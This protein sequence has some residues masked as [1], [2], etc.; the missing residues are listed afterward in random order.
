MAH[1][2][3]YVHLRADSKIP[4]YVGKGKNHRA[5]SYSDRSEYWKRV[6]ERHGVIVELLHDNLTEAVAFQ[7]EVEEI[8]WFRKYYHLVNYCDGG[9]GATKDEQ[10]GEK[11]RKIIEFFDKNGRFPSRFIPGEEN[12]THWMH[13]YCSLARNCFDS[14]FSQWC[15]ERGY[16]N[17]H[18]KEEKKQK[19]DDIREF[20][21]ANG[22]FPSSHRPTEKPLWRNLLSYCSPSHGCYDPEFR[23]WCVSNGYARRKQKGIHKES[24]IAKQEEIKQFFETHNRFP[25]DR[26]PDERTLH[27]RL[28]SYC[29]PTQSSFDPEFNQWCRDRG[30]GSRKRQ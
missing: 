9:E 13:A 12:M 27:V 5:W 7:E 22:R 8:A 3:V 6:A 10:T 16:G 30:Y 11:K 26:H 19:Q 21:K 25:R 14:N 1:F 23:D 24:K 4:F 29:A 15:R 18:I 17:E 28:N 20:L 2:Y